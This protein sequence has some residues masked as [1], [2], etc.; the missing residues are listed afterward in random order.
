MPCR[1]QSAG[2]GKAEGAEKATR[3]AGKDMVWWEDG[4][5]IVGP[6]AVG[7]EAGTVGRGQALK[8]LS[9]GLRSLSFG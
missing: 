2:D 8:A 7:E 6:D 4:E 1:S 3:E 5:R 9:A